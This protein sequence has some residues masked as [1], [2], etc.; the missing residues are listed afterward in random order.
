MRAQWDCYNESDAPYLFYI[1]N[2]SNNTFSI[3]ATDNP[4]EFVRYGVNDL[5]DYYPGVPHNVFDDEGTE[6]EVICIK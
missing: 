4:K 5:R 2:K 6:Y 1:K 3:V